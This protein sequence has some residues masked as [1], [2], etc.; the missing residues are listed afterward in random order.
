MHEHHCSVASGNEW[1]HV[2]VKAQ[3][4]DIVDEDRTNIQRRCS[5]AGPIRIYRYQSPVALDD[6]LHHGQD[7]LLLHFRWH[8]LCPRPRRLPAHVND[9]ST[10]SQHFFGVL[11]GLFRLEIETAIGKGVRRDVQDA[12]DV[13]TALQLQRRVTEA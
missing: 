9:V 13:D 6:L 11:D 2:G 4:A 1:G 8:W 12:H 3:S 5:N 10:F 7:T